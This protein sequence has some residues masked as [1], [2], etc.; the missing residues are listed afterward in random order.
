MDFKDQEPRSYPCAMVL[1]QSKGLNVPLGAIQD[2]SADQQDVGLESLRF[3]GVGG[4]GRAQGFFHELCEQVWGGDPSD[5]VLMHK[6][7]FS[8]NGVSQ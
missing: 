8:G 4:E 1:T 2:C 5:L 3:L 7:R 6:A